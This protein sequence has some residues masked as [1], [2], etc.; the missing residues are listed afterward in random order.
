MTTL[1]TSILEQ[2]LDLESKVQAMRTAEVK[3]D[4]L[5]V[6][7]KLDAFAKQVEPGSML[8]HYLERKSYEKARLWLQGRDAEN[9]T[10]ACGHS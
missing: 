8:R 9:V 5:P 4:L 10:G 3:P 1:E 7:S 2:L 6:F